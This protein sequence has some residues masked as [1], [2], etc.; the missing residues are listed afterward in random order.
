MGCHIPKDYICAVGTRNVNGREIAEQHLDVCLSAGFSDNRNK[1][2]V[3]LGQWEYQL[4][5]KG[6]KK[7]SDDLWLSRYLLH[8]ICEHYGVHVEF[9]PNQ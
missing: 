3:L 1:C 2:G 7:A 5:G 9:H 4:F 6:P 8:R